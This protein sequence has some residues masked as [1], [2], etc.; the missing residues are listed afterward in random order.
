M[1]TRVLEDAEGPSL[2]AWASI[3]EASLD[4][5]NSYSIWLRPGVTSPEQ[6]KSHFITTDTM[7][8]TCLWCKVVFEQIILQLKYHFIINIYAFLLLSGA[9]LY[10][11]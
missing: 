11:G 4:L 9:L 2:S 6:Q 10:S 5:R 8:N 3:R 7:I 1:T